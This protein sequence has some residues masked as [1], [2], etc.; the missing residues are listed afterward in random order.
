MKVTPS[1][2]VTINEY[3]NWISILTPNFHLFYKPISLKTVY[4]QLTWKELRK[5]AVAAS[6]LLIY[7]EFGHCS[8]VVR[9]LWLSGWVVLK[10]RRN[11]VFDDWRLD[12]LIRSYLRTQVKIVFASRCDVMLKMVDQLSRDSIPVK[13]VNSDCMVRSNKIRFVHVQ[14]I[15]IS[16]A[17]S[18]PLCWP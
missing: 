3:E 5:L 1:I 14:W 16:Y 12:S 9:I 17:R 2:M 15:M 10:K 4:H 6:F 7:A 8:H 18:E 11:T 13:F